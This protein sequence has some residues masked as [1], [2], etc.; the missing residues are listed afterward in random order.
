MTI[1]T[2]YALSVLFFNYNLHGSLARSQKLHKL[3][4][5]CKEHLTSF[6]P[7]RNAQTSSLSIQWL[8][9]LTILNLKHCCQLDM[10]LNK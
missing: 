9:R 3:F 8:K 5:T 2:Q 7:L 6:E 1:L 4:Y 10:A